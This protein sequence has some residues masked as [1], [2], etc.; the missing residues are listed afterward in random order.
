MAYCIE[1]IWYNGYRCSCCRHDSESTRWVNTLD[2]AIAELPREFPTESE[3]GGTISIRV[4]DG[5]TGN[6]VAESVVSWP[7]AYQRGDGYRFT[8]WDLRIDAENV[9]L[10]QIIEGTNSETKLRPEPHPVEDGDLPPEGFKFVTDRTW[11]DICDALAEK[12]R[13][14][15]LAKAQAELAAAEKRVKALSRG[16]VGE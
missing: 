7:P 5:V 11:S 10:T 9:S 3:H 15:D 1:S 13:Q 4:R 6:Y 14:V 2:E 16:S 12:K 8:R